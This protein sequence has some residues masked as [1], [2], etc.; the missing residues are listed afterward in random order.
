V[1]SGHEGGIAEGLDLRLPAPELSAL[2]V[3]AGVLAAGAQRDQVAGLVGTVVLP[4]AGVV[5]LERDVLFRLAAGKLAAVLV[6]VQDVFPQ[7]LE[8]GLFA[9]LVLDAGD[10]RGLDFLNIELGELDGDPAFRTRVLTES[11]ATD[12][13]LGES[14]NEFCSRPI[15]VGVIS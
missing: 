8:A 9:L 14:L 7:A 6:A 4:E 5:D 15:D 13:G 2:L 1:S 11:E 10:L 3:L 12:L